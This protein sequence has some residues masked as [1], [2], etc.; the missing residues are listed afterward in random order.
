MVPFFYQILIKKDRRKIVLQVDNGDTTEGRITRRVDVIAPLY[1][2]GLPSIFRPRDGIVSRSVGIKFIDTLRP[3]QNDYHFADSFFRCIFVNENCW[4]F[5]IYFHWIKFVPESL[6][7][8]KSA[9]AQKL[10]WHW[11]GDK[12]LPETVLPTSMSFAT[13]RSQW[14]DGIHD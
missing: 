7:D 8:S 9:L 12:P 14:V 3:E 11:I 1:V 6:V 13:T 5:W 10:A 4:P 2:G